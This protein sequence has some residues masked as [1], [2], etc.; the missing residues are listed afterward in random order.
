[1]YKKGDYVHVLPKPC[2]IQRCQIIDVQDEVVVVEYKTSRLGKIHRRSVPRNRVYYSCNSECHPHKSHLF[3]NIILLTLGL[4]IVYEVYSCYIYHR[5][6]YN[7]CN[8]LQFP[9]RLLTVC[10]PPSPWLVS[11]LLFDLFI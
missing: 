6:K 7:L 10:K 4:L 2:G 9:Y 5:E 3:R 11:F 8:S 1:M